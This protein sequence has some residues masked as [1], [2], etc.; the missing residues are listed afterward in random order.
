MVALRWDRRIGPCVL[1]VRILVHR[2]VEPGVVGMEANHYLLDA[3]QHALDGG[4]VVALK[5]GW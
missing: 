3:A 1:R 5:G 4:D 2:A